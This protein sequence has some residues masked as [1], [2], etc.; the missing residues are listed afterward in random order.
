[1]PSIPESFIDDLM[2]RV[3]LH[4]LLGRYITLKKVGSRFMGVCPFHGDSNPS[5][6]VTPDKGF[7]YCFG[8]QA[9]GDA[10]TF[11]RKQENLDFAEAVRFI[12]RLYG[13]PVP[14]GVSDP[15]AA[16]RRIIVDINDR[17]REFFTKVLKSK[18]GR[19]FWE[20]LAGRGFTKETL[21]D[22]RLGASLAGWDF[23]AKYLAKQGF[24]EQDLVD[25]GVVLPRKEAG[26]VYDRFRGRL[27]IPIVDTL[28]RTL[29]FGARA[30]GADE[31]KYINS[32]ESRIFQKSKVL[33]GLDLAKGAC[34]KSGQLIIM[35]G[36]TDVM[37]AHQAGVENSCAVMGTALTSDHLPLL[38]RF[39]G[40]IVLAFDGDE[41]GRRA[42][43]R[44]L[45]ALAGSDFIVKV[46]PLPLG[47][48]P[49]DIIRTE[50]ADSFSQRVA[51]ASEGSGWLFQ[52]YGEPVRDKPIADRL[53]AFEEI[54]GYLTAF[55]S[56]PVY[57]ELQEHAA[58]AFNLNLSALRTV[59]RQFGRTRAGQG[60]GLGVRLEAE[61][62]GGEEVER[63]LF[64]SLMAHPQYLPEVRELLDPEDFDNPLHRRLARIF[65]QPGFA[66]GTGEGL[67]RLREVSEDDDL[68]S[69]VVG[70][71]I[72]HEEDLERGEEGRF[73]EREL[74]SSL[75]RMV[76]RQWETES[77]R[78]QA[79]MGELKQHG[80]GLDE[81]GQARLLELMR[82][83]QEL[84]ENFGRIGR[85][86]LGEQ[87]AEG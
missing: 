21:V 5:L 79:C 54:A 7:W 66:I 14:E 81:A 6:S 50:G 57:D 70:L 8:C 25:A 68:H 19:P 18:H 67:R 1:M 62:R 34:R 9:G 15:H 61:I 74:R 45:L 17:A 82:Q 42:T 11:I 38:A 29:G 31:P 28:D 71:T 16:R 75:L 52:T 39:A 30:M 32:P 40:E 22:Y 33:F 2:A 4:D 37:Q 78:L 64:L 55:S 23:L 10:I 51:A 80:G 24:E 87:A 26:G 60:R 53:R 36:Y 69:Y 49:A 48:D 65:F 3:D 73:T 56:H 84:D 72:E 12:A 86:L 41:A 46:L 13:I 63:T 20:Y 59:L 58:I 35:E 76:T 85:H 27:M 47:S 43:T 77:K 83:R 44:S